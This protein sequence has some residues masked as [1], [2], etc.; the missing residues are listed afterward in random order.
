MKFIFT[1][2]KDK[3]NWLPHRFIAGR[4]RRKQLAAFLAIA[5]IPLM[6]MGLVSYNIAA[7]A[8]MDQAAEK[9]TGIRKLKNNSVQEYFVER[10]KD[11][12]QLSDTVFRLYEAG[13]DKIHAVTS[14]ENNP[15]EADLNNAIKKAVSFRR[16]GGKADLI[17][18]YR[19]QSGFENVY[20]ISAS[21]YVFHAARHGS[22]RYTNLLTGPYKNTNLGRLVAK[23]LK[24]KSYGMADF[25][26]YMPAQN[27][28]AAFM[29]Q[30]VVSNGKVGFVVAVQ[31]SIHQI[32]A[33]AGERTSLGRSGETYFVG[34]DKMFRNDSHRL[35]KLNVLTTIL[36]PDYK[37]DTKASRSALNGDSGTQVIK[38]YEGV[39]TLSSW[40]PLTIIEPNPVNPEGIRWALITEVDAREINQPM[41]TFTLV[42]AGAMGIAVL[43]VI[44][45]AYLLSGGL[46]RQIRHIMELFSEIGMGNFNARC[47]VVSRDELG[48]MA[49][50]LNAMLDN[51]LHLIQ[52][53]DE[54]DEI[55]NSIM[56]LLTDISALTEG[57]LTIRAEVTEDMTGAIAD[58]FNTM[59][60]QLS[61]LVSNVKESTLEVSTTSRQVSE[62]T[63]EMS[64][65]S[66]EHAGRI[67]EAVKVIGEM[68]ESINKVSEHASQSAKVSEQAMQ[69]ALSGA[70]AVRETNTAMNAIRERVQEAARAIKRLGESSQ[71]IG[72][73]VQIINDIADRT[74]ILALNASIQ[75]AM[76]GDAGRGF[77]VVADEVQ[78]LAEQSTQSTKQ[79]ETLVKTIQGEINEAG[80][81]MEDS[82]QRVV[83]G[84]QLADGAHNKLE[85]IEAVSQQLAKLVQAISIAAKQQAASSKNIS[86]T[87]KNVGQISS[88]AS[89]QGRQTALSITNLAKTSE[90]LRDSVDVFKLE[91]EIPDENEAKL[92]IL[93]DEDL[94]T[95]DYEDLEILS[96]EDSEILDDEDLEILSEA[97]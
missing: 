50:S 29:A 3:N 35:R 97:V 25:E 36:S 49:N 38:N 18:D 16:K 84:T 82:I 4:I 32:N 69:S 85:E 22:D 15:V 7:K 91:K 39:Q 57:D 83:H 65:T 80:T 24:T 53:S 52:S 54:R 43:L 13:S 94:E 73:I 72:N 58:S 95:L 19:K 1:R 96:D 34:K 90:Q 46:T 68:S 23:V 11:L 33:V 12:E 14:P 6:A 21:G 75:A 48:T 92:E 71:E 63:I 61:V 77:A 88:Q 31:L 67:T 28:P 20:L 86:A 81:R 9:L 45:G 76:A 40:Q 41:E 47:R 37:V 17:K 89:T 44:G 70:Q 51:V 64:R 59:A 55:Q 93:N 60:E 8:L 66:D 10:R 30:P 5:L 42:M 62:T 56:K 87:M 74:S 78:R 2:L 26:T 79:I 27:A